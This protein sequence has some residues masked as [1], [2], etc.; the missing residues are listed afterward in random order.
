M[1]TIVPKT[2]HPH[3]RGDN[4]LFEYA[5]GRC[6]GPSPRARGKRVV[7]GICHFWVRTIPTSAGKTIYKRTSPGRYSDHPHERGENT[8]SGA[9]LHADRGP[10]PR[11]RG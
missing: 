1:Q 11:A 10:S 5:S 2:D 8:G 6:G 7:I 3:A 4:G 9:L